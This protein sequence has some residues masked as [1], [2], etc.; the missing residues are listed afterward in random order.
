M[1]FS[2]HLHHCF[3]LKKSDTAWGGEGRLLV[4]L[5]VMMLLV[6]VV[7]LPLARSLVC[8]NVLLLRRNTS[9][10]VFSFPS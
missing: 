2:F 7:Q 6:F 8:S 4:P 9:F 5:F 10:R 3:N 1:S